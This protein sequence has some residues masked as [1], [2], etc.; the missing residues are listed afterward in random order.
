M[1]YTD[2]QRDGML[3]GPNLEQLKIFAENSPIPTIASGGVSSLNDIE[4]IKTLIN[5]NVAGVIIGKAI[6]EGNVTLQELSQ[7]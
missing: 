2:I 3:R 5:L 7:C 4:E 6:Y 1:I